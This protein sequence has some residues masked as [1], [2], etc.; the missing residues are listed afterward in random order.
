MLQQK[1]CGKP[2]MKPLENASLEKKK[3]S[4]AQENV[5]FGILKKSDDG[6]E[7]IKKD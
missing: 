7:I 2:N 6:K 3:S 1:L 5:T 4:E